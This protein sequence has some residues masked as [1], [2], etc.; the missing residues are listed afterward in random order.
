[1]HK[2]LTIVLLSLGASS[3]VFAATTV[4]EIDP[5]TGTSALTLLTGAILLIRNRKSR[6]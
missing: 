1:M 6:R 4:P 5:G 3:V 2:V